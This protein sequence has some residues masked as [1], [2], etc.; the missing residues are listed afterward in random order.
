MFLS[1]PKIK[2]VSSIN[3]DGKIVIIVCDKDGK[4]FYS[5]RQE[6]HEDN[7]DKTTLKGWE[8][9]SEL[10]LPDEPDDESVREKEQEELSDTEGNPIIRSLYRTKN[11]T[12]VAPVQLV[13]GMGHLYIFRQLKSARIAVDRFVLDGLTNKLVRK[14]QVRFKR[15]RQQF[16]PM[17]PDTGSTNKVDSYDFR[18]S[19]NKPF[20]EPTTELSILPKCK[21]G[22]FSVVLLPTQQTDQYRWSIFI[23]NTT[24]NQLELWSM[25]A[26]K[27]GLFDIRDHKILPAITKRV[28]QISP[29]SDAGSVGENDSESEFVNFTNGPVAS[30]YDTQIE[31]MT[32]E[33]PQLLRD[34]TKV[35]LVIPTDHEGKA[36]AINFSVNGDGFLS[37]LTDAKE[38]EK[39]NGYTRNIL[40][41]I[42]S[43]DEIKGIAQNKA[44]GL[45]DAINKGKKD[46]AV[47]IETDAE[48][49]PEK[50]DKVEISRTENFQ[51]L[52]QVVRA[53]SNTV[54]IETG[55]ARESLGTWE[56][57]LDPQS[58]L[59]F[60][61]MITSFRKMGG[62]RIRITSPKHGLKKG[63]ELQLEGDTEVEGIFAVQHIKRDSFSIN[64]KWSDSQIVNI[65]LKSKQRRGI[66]FDAN[67]DAEGDAVKTP[68]LPLKNPT[69]ETFTGRTISTWVYPEDLSEGEQ[70]VASSSSDLL[71]LV[72]KDGSMR[73]T[74]SV[75]NNINSLL[76]NVNSLQDNESSQQ[77]ISLVD[78]TPLKSEWIHY[79]AAYDY[80]SQQKQT[81]VYLMR[82][83]EVVSEQTLNAKPSPNTHTAL[84]LKGQGQDYLSTYWK[85][86]GYMF[87]V[88][89]TDFSF[90]SWI[91]TA[92][93]GPILAK[94][95][96]RADKHVL[97][98]LVDD[99]TGHLAFSMGDKIIIQSEQSVKDDQ[100]HHVAVTL[101]HRHNK[102]SLF[103]DGKEVKTQQAPTIDKDEDQFEKTFSIAYAGLDLFGQSYFIGAVDEVRVWKKALTSRK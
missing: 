23:Y 69:T 72:I 53:T 54:I 48:A 99:N 20:Y 62:N 11:N 57:Q 84:V 83:G 94:T 89:K 79:A 76:N 3:H 42:N 1:I 44:E 8:D 101:S 96:F 95:G 75:L 4:I 102:L 33:G 51:G 2:H 7:Y 49:L 38:W 19:N 65:R 43:L 21:Q 63:D 37:E 10:S 5:I 85:R 87:D 50:G 27:E 46:D 92:V 31:R 81:R 25:A 40:L 32:E 6:G 47:W 35:M 12:A 71:N 73:A 60:D 24:T 97:T 39:L 41:P 90:E 9:W 67:T 26:S 68:V 36:V 58:S 28:I 70:L 61:G 86:E 30:K 82:D 66:H 13:S 100:W 91:K 59:L 78:P 74:L 14:L 34:R 80:D 15:S 64:M 29:P 77:Q 22:W 98:L 56:Q 17:E 16:K 88:S 93:G 18:D 45:I 55:E 52:H 103:I